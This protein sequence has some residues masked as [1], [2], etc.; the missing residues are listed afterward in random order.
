MSFATVNIWGI[1]GLG[2]RGM[3][4]FWKKKKDMKKEE[5]WAKISVKEKTLD[6]NVY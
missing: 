5:V 4:N 1:M 3:S 2:R 6:K